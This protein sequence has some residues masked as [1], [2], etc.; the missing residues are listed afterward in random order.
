MPVTSVMDGATR[1][2]DEVGEAALLRRRSL[3]VY[4][5]GADRSWM[6]SSIDINTCLGFG[7]VWKPIP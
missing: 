1:T 5:G 7:H 2:I 4:M 3:M 6:I